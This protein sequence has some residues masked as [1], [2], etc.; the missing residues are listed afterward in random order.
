MAHLIV[1]Q[2]RWRHCRSKFVNYFISFI[3]IRFP[4]A[5]WFLVKNSL[6]GCWVFH[7]DYTIGGSDWFPFGI[8]TNLREFIFHARQ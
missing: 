7:L 4:I 5:Y 1:G 6:N 3:M 2:L 8:G